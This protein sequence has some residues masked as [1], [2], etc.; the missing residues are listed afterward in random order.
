METAWEPLQNA[1]ILD[2]AVQQIAV[3]NETLYV[4]SYR[5]GMWRGMEACS[6]DERNEALHFVSLAQDMVQSG[7]F[8]LTLHP[9]GWTVSNT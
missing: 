5:H 4:H 1:C 3:I 9:N 7:A 8:E 6:L 2:V